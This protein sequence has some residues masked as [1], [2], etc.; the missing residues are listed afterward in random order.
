MG[1]PRR[2]VVVGAT[3]IALVVGG[4]TRDPASDGAPPS[5]QLH[6]EPL[7]APPIEPGTSGGGSTV[8]ATAHRLVRTLEPPLSAREPEQ[9]AV[10]DEFR[11]ALGCLES[12]PLGPD[13]KAPWPGNDLL[14]LSGAVPRRFWGQPMLIEP[15][16]RGEPLAGFKPAPAQLV[17]SGFFGFEI[18]TPL[19]GLDASEELEVQLHG[20]VVPPSDRSFTTRPL[21]IRGGDALVFGTAF[22]EIATDFTNGPVRFR[23]LALTENEG[24]KPRELFSTTMD[25]ATWDGTWADH[26]IDLT[27]LAGKTVRLR[28][29]SS[30]DDGS[31][32]AFPLWGAPELLR[33]THRGAQRNLIVISLDTW[34]HDHF[35]SD[36]SGGPVTPELAALAREGVVFE[37]AVTT[38]PSTS[39]SHMSLFTGLYPITH[40]VRF[41]NDV[42]GT[43]WPTLAEI[44][45]ANGYQTG[46]VTENAML[47]AEAGFMFG[48]DSYFE[49]KGLGIWS[50]QG[51]IDSTLE[52]GRSWLRRHADERFFLFLHTYQIHSPYEPPAKFVLGPSAEELASK[53]EPAW[54]T[55]T[56]HAYAGEVR[57]ADGALAGFLRELRQSGLLDQSIVV[58]T[59][60]HGE[61]F[62]EHGRMGHSKSVYEEVLR[63]PLI[64]WAP[65]LVRRGTRV[66][67]M[68]SLVDVVPTLLDLLEL[69]SPKPVQGRS[70][71]AALEGRPL[72]P[73]APRFAEGPDTENPGKRLVA[74][75]TDSHKWIAREG[76]TTPHEI[77]DLRTDP[78]ESS[79]LDDAEL[80]RA[81]QHLL[82][83]YLAMR[84]GASP[85]RDLDARTTEKLRALG[86]VE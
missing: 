29:H 64:V 62:G 80:V 13:T 17:E 10:A 71:R 25:P 73:G 69:T 27:P 31:G 43:A 41:A 2:A 33:R 58:L 37:H 40:Q 12:L 70:L 8:Y 68:V 5:I 79:V 23:V 72:V 39:A 44:L 86:Y 30:P 47:L 45:G 11:L 6:R 35:D 55:K 15:R 20:Y 60:D 81:G 21:A 59:S 32:M 76:T 24:A 75:R 78:D 16:L 14:T 26:R 51:Q 19:P 56:R 42:L 28:L 53:N 63:V 67:S 4:C 61:E 1:R 54:V 85:K 50:T 66:E 36:V 65:G 3:T 74:A 22:N 83:S 57:Y 9:C 52:R 18:D 38:Y 46:A 34:R 77:Y 49:N 84:S 7:T 82:A 48:F